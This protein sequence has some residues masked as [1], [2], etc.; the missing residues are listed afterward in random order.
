MIY[1]RS[2]RDALGGNARRA[3]QRLRESVKDRQR[4][5]DFPAHTA[6]DERL[7]ETVRRTGR[8]PT[9]L[10]ATQ[11]QV[12]TSDLHP[13]H[14]TT[15]T[16]GREIVR[17]EQMDAHLPEL[18]AVS[19]DANLPQ[20][21]LKDHRTTTKRRRR[22]AHRNDS[23][24]RGGFVYVNMR[25]RADP[26]SARDFVSIPARWM[27]RAIRSGACEEIGLTGVRTETT[28]NI[29]RTAR[30]EPPSCLSCWVNADGS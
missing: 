8:N 14:G 19:P 3:K 1:S 4:D 28:V 6:T 9:I 23:F 27:R 5:G 12:D 15:M 10:T 26:R 29:R 21:A 24:E 25:K 18:S 30:A 7:Y 11:A 16:F 17:I 22:H 2:T 20:A 13:W